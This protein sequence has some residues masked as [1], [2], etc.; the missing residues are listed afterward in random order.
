MNMRNLTACALAA[1]LWGGSAWAAEPPKCSDPEVE[2][3]LASLI[4]STGLGK[5]YAK[6][7]FGYVGT[8]VTDSDVVYNYALDKTKTDGIVDFKFEAERQR[9]IDTASGKRYCTTDLSGS[10]NPGGMKAAIK[11]GK[12]G[13]LRHE[14]DLRP[15]TTQ[16]MADATADAAK[17]VPTFIRWSNPLNYSVQT[18]EKGG[19]I[20]TMNE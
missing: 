18:L 2:R 1:A 8:S 12:S 7:D 3:S 17:K 16:E 14:V 5:V 13:R 10:I 15:L 9:R 11:V 20:V 19:A 6:R 4:I